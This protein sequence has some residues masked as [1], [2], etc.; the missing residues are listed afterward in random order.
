MGEHDKLEAAL[1]RNRGRLIRDRWLKELS[2]ACGVR[3]T[4]RDLLDAA[5]TARVRSEF[6]SRVRQAEPLRHWNGDQLEAMDFV[7]ALGNR[8]EGLRVALLSPVDELVGACL[9]DV[10]AVLS[11]AAQV[12]AAIHDDLNLASLDLADGM[13]LQWNVYT[14][15]GV[16]TQQGALDFF[17][18]GRFA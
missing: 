17:G 7:A 16:Y 13:S 14:G 9:V 3:L 2:E 15:E 12:H 6:F 5:Q 4:E 11:R 8:N 10:A 1:R 18:W